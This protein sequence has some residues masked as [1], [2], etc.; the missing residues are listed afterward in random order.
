MM[1]RI[2]ATSLLVAACVANTAAQTASKP[3]AEHDR[4]RSLAGT[5]NTEAEEEGFKYTLRETCEWFA[6]EFHL[7]CRS[8]GT[9]NAS[10]LRAQTILGYDTR[11]GTYTRYSHNSFGNATLMNGTVAG[12]VWTWSGEVTTGDGT[13][14]LRATA[15]EE[16]PNAQSYKVEGS[17][18]GTSWFVVEQGRSTKV[19]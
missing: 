12:S 8:D 3:G 7:V 15:T 18:D 1:K 13:I 2:V 4:L 6:G 5:W 19:Q 14:R 9:G 17:T 11:R 16:S 10:R